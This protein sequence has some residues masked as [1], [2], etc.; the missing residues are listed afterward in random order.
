MI[1]FVI[2]LLL[3]MS[4]TVSSHAMDR[5][6][7]GPDF[8]YLVGKDTENL[9]PIP[10][11]LENVSKD[12]KIVQY[13]LNV[14]KGVTEF[15]KGA[16]NV[17]YGYNGNL[18]G[19]TIRVK[20]GQKIKLNIKNSLWEHTTVHWHGLVV[21]GNVDGGP[22]QT[23]EP[24]FE[25]NPLFRI[26]QPAATAWY[27]PHG[28]GN[29]ASQ[30]YKGLAGLLIIDDEN[31]SKLP[32]P[33]DYGKNDIPLII[34]DRR[35]SSD[36]YLQYINSMQDIMEGMKGDT[37]LV[38]GV[39]NSYVKLP[40]KKIRFRLL[41]GSN[42]RVYNLSFDNNLTFYQIASDGGFLE[43]PI[44]LNKL[45][46]SPGERAEIIIDL[47]KFKKDEVIHLVSDQLRITKIIVG[48]KLEDKTLIP[49]K[50]VNIREVN[51]SNVV[52]RRH[53]KL[54]GMGHMVSINNKRMNIRRV[55]EYIKLNEKEI[56]TITSRMGMMMGRMH[57]MGNVV[58]NFHV[59]GIQFRVLERNGSHPPEN[60]GGWKDTI[61]L[62]DGESVKIL[63]KFTDPGI[64]MYHCHILE[65]ED[66][67]MMGQVE[68]R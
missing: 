20:R 62:R 4:G 1:I 19:P 17:T 16:K 61:L 8:E 54:F 18:L 30:V 44:G 47:S 27:H 68:V 45:V 58:H 41:N 55:D 28:I 38:N 40:A 42:A 10:P 50:L 67:G 33:K 5:P 49:R 60:E 11:L 65:H 37:V 21:P 35:F 51:L 9:L 63:T 25:W 59:H 26:K 13:K 12:P 14:Q 15:F 52:N 7:N 2:C 56:W 24:G 39:V 46:L 22:H 3:L 66:N 34:Q 32:I 31:S 43:K 6:S 36:G 48:E 64:F 53:F 23:I 29:T 57:G